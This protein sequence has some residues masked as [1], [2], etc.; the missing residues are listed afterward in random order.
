MK[1]PDKY[2]QKTIR[3]LAK[4]VRNETTYIARTKTVRHI[5]TAIGWVGIIVSFLES[6]EPHIPV[7]AISVIGIF[8]GLSLGLAIFF[9]AFLKQWPTLKAYIDRESILKDNDLLKP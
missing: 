1:N 9:E 6:L 3:E 8:G 2:S 7:W 4:L 5:L